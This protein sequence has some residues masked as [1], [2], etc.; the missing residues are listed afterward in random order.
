MKHKG[1]E[2]GARAGRIYAAK[3]CTALCILGVLAIL[4]L[5]GGADFQSAAGLAGGSSG[6]FV[7]RA[8]A[9]AAV[10]A[11]G[12]LGRKRCLASAAR[13]KRVSRHR[14]ISTAEG[15]V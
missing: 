6:A 3:A 1:E 14:H 7:L 4:G 8:A 11:G 2:T 5:A 9:A 15:R 12:W 13:Q 10:T